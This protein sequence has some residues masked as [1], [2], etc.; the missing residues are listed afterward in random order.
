MKQ[1]QRSTIHWGWPLPGPKGGDGSVA[2]LTLPLVMLLTIPVGPLLDQPLA[3]CV[4]PFAGTSQ[5]CAREMKQEQ[6]RTSTGPEYPL[7]RPKGVVMVVSAF[8]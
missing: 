1:E 3:T 7:F 5:D 8:L 6:D 2:F 4:G